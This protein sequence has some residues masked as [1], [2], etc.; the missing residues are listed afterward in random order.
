MSI[1][2]CLLSIWDAWVRLFLILIPVTLVTNMRG[3]VEPT[4]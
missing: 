1:E 4:N 2:N 3:S